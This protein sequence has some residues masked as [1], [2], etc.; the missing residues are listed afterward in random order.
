MLFSSIF[1]AISSSID[2]LGIGIT[3]GLKN[4]KISYIAN[5]ILFS[6]SIIITTFSMWFGNCISNFFTD[7]ITNIIGSLIIIFMGFFM[8]IQ[9]L[10]KDSTDSNDNLTIPQNIENEK[11]HSFFIKFLGITIQIIRNP[12]SSDFDHSKKID[13]KEAFFLAIALSLDSFCIGIGSTIAGISSSL[14]PI[15][16]STFQLL[17]LK[18]GYFI[19][20]KLTNTKIFPDNTWSI[21]SGILLI[22]IGLFKFFNNP[23]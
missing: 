15:F 8:T 19:G 14:F 23:M 17:F 5:I 3:Y 22:I 1:L 21:L 10:K 11:I 6:I 9:A 7:T 13:C 16:I 12:T 4:T 20:N 2:A 18:L